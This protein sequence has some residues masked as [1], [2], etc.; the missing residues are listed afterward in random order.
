MA[1]YQLTDEQRIQLFAPLFERIKTELNT[2][3]NGDEQ[4]MWA[5]QRK[6]AKELTYL[7]R[8]KPATRKKLKA[9]M[10]KKQNSNCALCN[11]PM[12]QE[13][14][15]LDRYEACLGYIESNVR[16]VHHE[17]HKKDQADKNYA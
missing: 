14:S 17:C 4:L 7:E 3:S 15:E 8:G 16:L 5:L 2:L 11:N 10:W 6:L 12:P 1:N 9:I 13:Y